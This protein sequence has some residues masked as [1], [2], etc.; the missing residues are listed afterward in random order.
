MTPEEV[1]KQFGNEILSFSYYY[2]GTFQFTGS[3]SSHILKGSCKINSID[4]DEFELDPSDS[5]YVKEF[6]EQFD[7]FEIRKFNPQNHK[8][9]IIFNWKKPEAE[10]T[11]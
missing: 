10:P 6:Q 4:N 2:K 1:I 8:V 7:R 9:E 5:I 11:Q 3:K